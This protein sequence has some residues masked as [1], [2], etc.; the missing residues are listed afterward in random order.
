MFGER[1]TGRDIAW[2]AV[3]IAGV[4]TV[5]LGSASAQT[6]DPVGDALAAV[7]MLGFAGYL[8]ASKRARTTLGAFEYQSSLSVVAAAALVPVA[9]L[10]GH[11][12]LPDSSS[13]PWVA[14]MVAL[15]G[16]GH[17]LMN[18]AHGH[19]RLSLMG[20]IS[21]LAPAFSALLAWAILDESLVPVQVL[22]I[23]VAVFA[24]AVLVRTPRPLPG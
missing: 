22:G 21:V 8:V 10:S 12:A 18:Y 17:L 11:L 14:A 6:G 1:P 9:L 2:T 7:A 24:L 20:V 5:V 13:W 19:V 15:P 3:S 16:S 23:G 4:A